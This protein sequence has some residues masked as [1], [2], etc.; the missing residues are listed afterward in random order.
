VQKAIT[1]WAPKWKKRGWRRGKKRVLNVDLWQRLDAA[2]AP[3]R[4]EWIWVRG[5]S[6]NPGNECADALAAAPVP[7]MPDWALVSD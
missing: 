2:A 6:G 1:I 7:P 4:I 5:H 3:H